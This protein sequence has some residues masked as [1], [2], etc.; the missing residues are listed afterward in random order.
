[1]LF[2][3]IRKVGMKGLVIFLIKMLLFVPSA[4]PANIPSELKFAGSGNVFYKGIIKVYEAELFIS[5]NAVSTNVLDSDVSRCLKLEYTVDLVAEKFVFAA[6][7]IL[8]RQHDGVTLT[9]IEQY[10]TQFH[11]A[12][13]NVAA[14]DIYRMCFDAATQTMSL[15]LNGAPL[16]KVQSGAF[17]RIYFGIWLGEKT[18]ISNRLRKNLLKN[19]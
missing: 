15:Q 17:A 3:S 14:G 1:M 5:D 10:L 18:P 7:K 12:Y 8:K 16:I 6:E 13:Q 2:I 4:A 19:L 11:S 9:S